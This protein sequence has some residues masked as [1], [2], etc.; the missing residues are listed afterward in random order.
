[1]ES[2]ATTPPAV[3]PDARDSL[4]QI[5]SRHIAPVRIEKPPVELSQFE[6]IDL[7]EPRLDRTITL[8][9]ALKSRHSERH[10][11]PRP[12][13]LPDL[14]DM[15]WSALGINRATGER[16]VPF[17][18]HVMAIDMYVALPQGV[19]L[20]EPK[21][22]R[23]CPY[24]ATD[25]RRQTGLQDFVATAPVNLIYVARGDDMGELSEAD[26]MLYAS[27]DAAFIGQNVYLFCAAAG[28]ATVFRGALDRSKLAHALMLP[29]HQFVTFA[30][31]VGYPSG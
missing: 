7:P 24:L 16:T 20:Y 12:L 6:A 3:V 9:Q 17:W 10:Y 28:L 2:I 14:S 13:T 5:H 30:Q 26:R 11:S 31:S 19:W 4:P 27:V 22:H 8:M 29:G 25:L 23:L 15:L 1:M 18:R 21:D